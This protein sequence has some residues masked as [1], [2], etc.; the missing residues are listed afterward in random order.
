MPKQ[1]SRSCSL[2]AADL[3]KAPS[4]QHTVGWISKGEGQLSGI[5]LALRKDLVDELHGVATE[6]NRDNAPV[7]LSAQTLQ[8]Q[9][10]T[11]TISDIN[12]L[13]KVICLI[14]VS[15]SLNNMSRQIVR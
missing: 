12:S 6:H 15:W 5:R 3:L 2:A 14:A 7:D 8:I 11:L 10:G 1:C 13:Q 9:I 4:P